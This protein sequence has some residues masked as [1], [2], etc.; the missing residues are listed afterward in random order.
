MLREKEEWNISMHEGILNQRARQTRLGRGGGNGNDNRRGT[1]GKAAAAEVAARLGKSTD[2]MNSGLTKGETTC[3]FA[4]KG[5]TCPYAGQGCPFNHKKPTAAAP[6]QP[7]ARAKSNA[8]PAPNSNSRGRSEKPEGGGRKAQSR[9]QTP[10]GGRRKG[11][12]QR[13]R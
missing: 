8:A 3:K 11:A 7:G 4:R 2:V 1:N 10:T 6:A 5:D 13:N 9:S 12:Q